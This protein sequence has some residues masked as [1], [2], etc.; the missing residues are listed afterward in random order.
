MELHERF[1]SAVL[2]ALWDA[3]F[4]V[5]AALLMHHTGY[6]SPTFSFSIVYWKN[7]IL[8]CSGLFAILGFIF[9]SSIGG[10]IG[11]VMNLVVTTAT[12]NN[13][14]DL[15]DSQGFWVKAVLV[16]GIAALVYWLV[17]D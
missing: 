8:G 17:K 15:L 12:R 4:G 14:S 2:G 11:T 13:E 7:M 5:V 10:L 6:R 3:V 9:K 1:V 16:C